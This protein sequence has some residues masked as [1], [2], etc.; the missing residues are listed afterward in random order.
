MLV[1]LPMHNM[2]NLKPSESVLT[3]IDRAIR[4]YHAKSDSRIESI[5]FLEKYLHCGNYHKEKTALLDR[6]MAQLFK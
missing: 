5:R 1:P 3:G 6:F 2:I 4:F